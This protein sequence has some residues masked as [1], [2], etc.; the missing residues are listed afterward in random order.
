MQKFK[1]FAQALLIAFVLV[2]CNDD[3]DAPEGD[4]DL[5]H[6]VTLTDGET[7]Y[8]FEADGVSYTGFTRMPGSIE[9]YWVF[10]FFDESN[11]SYTGSLN[12]IP[13]E[14]GTYKAGDKLGAGNGTYGNDLF[15]NAFIQIDNTKY[16]AY[17]WHDYGYLEDRRILDSSCTIRLTKVDGETMTYNQRF[18]NIATYTIVQFIGVIEGIFSGKFTSIEGESIVVTKGEFRVENVLPDNAEVVE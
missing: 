6:E 5:I 9:K 17:S 8:K 18:G 15:I 7:G 16:Y 11:N 10:N 12:W 13:K 2:S 14:V 4:N 1:T 3:M